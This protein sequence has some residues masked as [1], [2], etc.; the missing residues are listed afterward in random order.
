MHMRCQR[1]GGFSARGFTLIELLTVIAVLSVVM[2]MGAQMFISV[3]E[4]RQA[5]MRST[6]LAVNAIQ[7]LDD[8]RVDFGLIFNRRQP[9]FLL[10]QKAPIFGGF[11]SSMNR[12][13]SSPSASG[14]RPSASSIRRIEAIELITSG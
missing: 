7:A 5:S 6:Q 2:T 13:I 8:M 4:V 14:G 10:R 11:T 1:T 3:M 12:T 9:V